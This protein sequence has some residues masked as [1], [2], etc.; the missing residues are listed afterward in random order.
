MVRKSRQV[1]GSEKVDR[2]RKINET[3]KQ[4]KFL[5]HRVVFRQVDESEKIDETTKQTSYCV[6]VLFRTSLVRESTFQEI[7]VVVFS[8]PS[9]QFCHC[10]MVVLWEGY[11]RFGVLHH[12]W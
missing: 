1:D 9:L 7:T 8:S 2:P 10:C 3:T 4:T 5:C 11:H 6:T 12:T